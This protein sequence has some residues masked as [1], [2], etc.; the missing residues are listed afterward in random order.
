MRYTRGDRLPAMTAGYGPIER[1][2]RTNLRSGQQLATPTGAPF[3]LAT[4]DERG[5]VLLL[6]QQEAHTRLTWRCLEGIRELLIS[7]SWMPIGGIYDTSSTP[8]TLDAYLKGHIKRVT[9]GWV[10]SVLEAA[11]IVDIN[12]ARPAKV[13]LRSYSA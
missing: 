4:I 6:G 9:A 2:I 5:L 3:T 1:A 12:R 7:G 10:A 8:G 13:R 11:G